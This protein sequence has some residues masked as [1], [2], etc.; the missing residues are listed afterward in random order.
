MKVTYKTGKF[1]VEAEGNTTEIFKQLA[2]FD[3]VFGNCVTRIV[4]LFIY[5]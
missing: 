5:L 2:S 4:L 1:T 3:S